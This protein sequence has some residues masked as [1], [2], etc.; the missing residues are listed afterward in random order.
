MIRRGPYKFIYCDTDPSQLYNLEDD[1][2]E[3]TN[4]CQSADKEIIQLVN[5]F[6]DEIALRW[7]IESLRK[8]VLESQAK[9]RF[10]AAALSIGE[11]TVWDHQPLFPAHKEFIR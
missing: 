9:R 2:E 1:P 8:E 7:D 6:H 3:M 5:A 10:V 11:K 4:L